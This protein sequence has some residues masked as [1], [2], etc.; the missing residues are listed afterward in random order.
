MPEPF[1]RVRLKRG[2]LKIQLFIVLLIT[3]WRFPLEAG[4]TP[5]HRN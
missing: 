1:L 3:Q 2:G 4:V 5:L